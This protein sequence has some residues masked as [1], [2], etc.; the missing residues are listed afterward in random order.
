MIDPTGY[1]V[2]FDLANQDYQP[3]WFSLIVAVGGAIMLAHFALTTREL[4][5]RVFV[6]FLAC[7]FCLV[8]FSA[9]S[10]HWNEYRQLRQAMSED[11]YAIL[12]SRVADFQPDPWDG[13]GPQVFSVAGHPFEIRSFDSTTA[14]GRTVS[15]GGPDLSNKC[16]RVAFTQNEATRQ[17]RIV[18]LAIRRS[19]CADEAAAT[20]ADASARARDAPLPPTFTSP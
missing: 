13:D 5:T 10:G 18:W 7:G 17:D 9:V 14:F 1:D 12:E 20:D 6:G 8:G 3:P 11:R 4:G 19:G 16:V 15:E 2:V